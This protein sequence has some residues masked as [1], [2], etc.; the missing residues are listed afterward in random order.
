LNAIKDLLRF[1]FEPLSIAGVNTVQRKQ[2]SD[3]RG[4]LSRLFCSKNLTTI[5][6]IWP[7]AQVNYTHTL[8]AGTVR[9]I[10][11]QYSPY[12]EAKLVTCIRGRILDVAVDLRSGSPTFLKWCTQELSSENL[13][14]MLIPPGCAHGYQSL[15][16]DVELI[17]FHSTAYAPSA[18]SGLRPTDPRLGINWPLQIS[19][20]SARDNTFPLLDDFFVGLNIPGQLHR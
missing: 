11:Y 6:W 19:E 3:M 16:D 10:H 5:G 15:T 8:R 12:A 18:E 20:I 13:T 1:T 14:S 2:M 4:S 7:I 9:G 17:Y